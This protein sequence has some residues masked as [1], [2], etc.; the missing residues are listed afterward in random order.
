MSRHI[1]ATFQIASWDETPFENGDEATKLTE[2]LV[3]KRYEGDIQGTSTTKWLLAY[4]PDK[5]ALFVGIEHVTGTIA[6]ATG[7]LVLLH[8]GAYRD[9]VASGEVRIAS[10]TGG[11]AEAAGNGKFRAD[12]AGALTLDVDGL[13][14]A[15]T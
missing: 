15:V 7:G 3:S 10:G 11:L 4:G 12:P 14:I 2:A 5:S 6:G 9:G 1:E 8:D 13:D